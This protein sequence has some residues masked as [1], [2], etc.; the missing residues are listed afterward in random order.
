MSDRIV[1][2]GHAAV[3]CLGN[4]LDRTWQGLV[5]GKSGL[6]RHP[7]RL[8]PGSYLQ[9]IAGLVEGVGPGSAEED[10]AI[11]RLGSRFVHFG[12]RAARQAWLESGLEAKLDADL[13]RSRVAVVVGSG[14]GGMD[15]YH[16]E[17]KRA[18]SRKS[19]ATG[20]YLLPG[21]IA[22]QAAGQVAQQLGLHGP[23]LCPAN[24]CAS[25][26][27]AIVFG[28]MLLRSGE[29]DVAVVGATESAF[30]PEIV[31]GFVTMKALMGRK[32]NDRSNDDP[33]QASRPFSGDRAGFLMAEGA[34]ILVLATESAVQR[35]GL[36]PLA[37]L[38]GW[39][40][41]SDGFHVAQPQPDRVRQCLEAAIA[42]AG[43]HPDQIDYYNAHGTSTTIND[44]VETEA[45]RRIFGDRA[46]KLPVS[47][48]KGAIGHALGAAPAI[49]AAVCVR[50][51]REQA[52]P[53]TVNY[54]PD[55]ELDLDY[56]PNEGREVR[57][58]RILSASFGF[59]GTNNA[60]VFG[61][62]TDA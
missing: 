53:P 47:S 20:P 15:L 61:R 51:L 46:A 58:D 34:G 12:V 39:A 42:H 56:V 19:L 40:T 35:L 54:R 1:V 38:L 48:I 26:G 9:D 17:S 52:V 33:S 3:T 57:L 21:L 41:N 4:D 45:V 30:T 14:L 36:T 62:G 43:V 11:T 13:P 16:A 49:E 8:D 60:L 28:A 32:P 37:T 55:P 44:R 25:G 5:A 22:N 29:A 10:P 18:A 7:D 27:H 24:A 23:S 6:A 31:N 50:A 2:V 59:G